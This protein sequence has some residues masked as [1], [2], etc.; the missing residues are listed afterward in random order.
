MRVLVFITAIS[1]LVAFKKTSDTSTRFFKT[2][3]DSGHITHI[4]DGATTEWPDSL[5]QNNKESL[6]HYAEDNDAQNLYIAV[7]IA[8]FRTQMKMMRQGMKL[9]ID[10]KGKKREAKGIEFPIKPE[11]VGNYSSAGVNNQQEN[12]QGSDR[13]EQHGNFDK[14]QARAAMS[15][16]L[17]SMKLFGFGDTDDSQ[18]LQMA[19]SANVAFMWDSIDVMHIEY[20][21][22]LAL[23]G[24]IT[25]LK[26]KT[27]SLGW[28]IN[29]MEY[30]PGAANV[31]GFSSNT[32]GRPSG[33][34]GGTRGGRTAAP[35]STSSDSP[36]MM[37]MSEEESFWTKYIFKL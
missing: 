15:I 6:M 11:S 36:D 9:F 7:R 10:V 3:D 31:V 19:G 28:K 13:G 37:R 24:D 14:K 1:L 29:G 23:L 22:P 27:I 32:Q 8:D 4:F 12:R 26:Q 34:S 17:F 33:G 18:G 21:I 5:F 20:I 16:H 2:A 30:G 25:S 35:V